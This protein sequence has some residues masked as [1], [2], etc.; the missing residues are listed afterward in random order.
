MLVS[1][2][3]EVEELLVVRIRHKDMAEVFSD[4]IL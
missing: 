3:V 4:M 1:S 2:L